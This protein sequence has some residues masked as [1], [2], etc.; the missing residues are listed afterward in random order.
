VAAVRVTDLAPAAE[1]FRDAL[2][3]GLARVPKAI[4]AKFIYDALGSRLFEEIGTL[5]EYY[6]K[7]IEMALL[8]AHAREIAALVGPDA[9]LIEFGGSTNEKVRI[10]IEALDRPGAYAP[11]DLSRESLVAAAEAL[12]T[13]YP[14]VE[15]LPVVA[16]FTRPLALPSPRRHGATGRR[17][18]FFPGSTIGNL[19][20]AESV[21]FMA[22][23][24]RLVEPGGLFLVG[25]DLK[26]DPRVIEAAYNDSQGVSARFNT[27]V[28]RRANRELGADFDLARF[29]HRAVYDQERGRMDIGIESLRAQN[30]HVAGR[31]FRFE[32]GEVIRTQVAY[33]YTSDGFQEL[34]AQAGF[35]PE[36]AWTDGQG[37]YGLHLLAIR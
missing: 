2:V 35:R 3:A 14:A 32:A 27:N 4:P 5:G 7:R 24:L 12:A 28:L 21:A 11:V 30:V 19:E 22:G 15:V 34:A 20:P 33:K 10:L 1:S 25:I 16:D 17:V 8:S 13:D 6:P 29:R 23:V 26:K 36:R 31:V 9:Y 18:G 37:W